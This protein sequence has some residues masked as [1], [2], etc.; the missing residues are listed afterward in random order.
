VVGVQ[1]CGTEV[2]RELF[3]EDLFLNLAEEAENILLV[4]QRSDLLQTRLM[5]I[6]T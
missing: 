2:S 1:V 4:Q 3:D 5:K 6:V